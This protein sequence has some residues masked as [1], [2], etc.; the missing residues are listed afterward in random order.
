M[1][2]L[3]ET[4]RN[5]GAPMAGRPPA[6]ATE[7]GVR[8]RLLEAAVKMFAA[9]GFTGTS[10]RD[11]ARLAE[12][13]ECSIY[14]LFGTK[15]DLFWAA[16]RSSV[17]QIRLRR[18]LEGARAG[19]VEPEVALRLVVEFLV[20]ISVYQPELVRLL[21]TS[22]LELRPQAEL[23]QRQVMGPI[24]RLLSDYL[25]RASAADRLPGVD[26]SLTAIALTASILAHHALSPV[27]N[28]VSRPYANTEEAVATYSR[29]WLKLLAA[30][31]A[32]PVPPREPN[33]VRACR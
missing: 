21:G 11:I 15:Q 6:P 25:A 33:H 24:L 23:V 19:D 18:E 10:T 9:N 28:G 12:V 8:E 2:A 5:D 7:R 30:R 14:R 29:Y 27:L 26:P 13:N 4:S 20:N 3:M 31:P 17:E 22:W 16:L 1:K 32:D